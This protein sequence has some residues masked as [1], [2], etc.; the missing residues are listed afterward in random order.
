M[1]IQSLV[2]VTSTTTARSGFT[3]LAV[4]YA[5]FFVVSSPTVAAL[6]T[7]QAHP[8]FLAFLKASIIINTP[9]L[10]SSARLKKRPPAALQN[11]VSSTTGA[12]GSTSSHASSF[13]STPISIRKSDVFRPPSFLKK[14]RYD[15]TTPYTGPRSVITLTRWPG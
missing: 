2:Y 15:S 1:P 8:R 6:Y 13:E 4:Q 11:P 5:P 14:S 7:P 3:R 10:S 9:S 12:P